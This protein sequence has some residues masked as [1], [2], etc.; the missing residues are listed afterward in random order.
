MGAKVFGFFSD[1]RKPLKRNNFVSDCSYSMEIAS[2][3]S[4]PP[5]PPPL[6]NLL[7]CETLEKLVAR[8]R[9]CRTCGSFAEI[10]AKRLLSGLRQ[11]GVDKVKSKGLRGLISELM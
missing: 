3:S 1:M 9:N 8:G 5:P 7:S 4:A 10:G 2:N 11:K 6:H